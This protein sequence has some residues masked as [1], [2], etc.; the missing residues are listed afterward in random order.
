MLAREK[1]E[2]IGIHHGHE[3]EPQRCLKGKY[4]EK[5]RLQKI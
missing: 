3:A 2:G 4:D 1:I 5:G